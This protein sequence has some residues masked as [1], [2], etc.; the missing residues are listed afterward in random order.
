[1]NTARRSLD[2]GGTTTDA[3]AFGG[4]PGTLAITEAW[5]GTTWTEVADL[6]TGRAA[7]GGGSQ[8]SSTSL[9]IAFGGEVSGGS[10]TT[11]TEEWSIPLATV[12]FDLD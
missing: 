2:A 9:N 7:L 6:S 8:G 3:L 1:M 4:T 5:N 12:T 10:V 11:A